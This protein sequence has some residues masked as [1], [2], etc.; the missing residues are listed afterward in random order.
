M[1]ENFL[2]I[3]PKEWDIQINHG[4]ENIDY[5]K[6]IINTSKIISN[7][8]SEDRIILNNL[9]VKGLTHKE[10]SS[11]STSV[12]FWNSI[13]GDLLL[14]FEC[15]TILCPNSKYKI[16]DFEKFEYIGGYWGN[17]LYHPLDAPYPTL[18]PGGDY[19]APYNG[20]QVLPMNGALSIRNKK[21][22]INIIENN[23]ENYI[24]SGKPYVD[25]Y[26]FSEFI[27]KPLTKEVISFSIDN[28][29]ISPLNDEAPFGLHKPWANKGNAYEN[30]KRVCPEVIILESLQIIEN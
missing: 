8:Y 19:H 29:Y 10:E 6:N 13:K 17:Q 20:P 12:D 24:N 28:G 7:A 14:K 22:M 23:F 5:I 21:T 15:D 27:N 1:L 11:L 25:D 26:F 30:I 4:V 16:G 2:S 3:L 9:K 18:K